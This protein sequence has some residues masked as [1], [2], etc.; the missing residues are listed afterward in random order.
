MV[1]KS[2][3]CDRAVVYEGSALWSLWSLCVLSQLIPSELH[4]LSC[5]KASAFGLDPFTAKNVEFLGLYPIHNASSI[6][7]RPLPVNVV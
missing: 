3:M 6:H 7:R 5:E 4:I 2:V 1:L